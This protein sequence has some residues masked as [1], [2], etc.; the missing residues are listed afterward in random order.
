MPTPVATV[1]ARSTLPTIDEW[2]DIEPAPLGTYVVAKADAGLAGEIPVYDVPFGAPR[3]LVDDN[4]IDGV[5]SV[6]VRLVN[7]VDDDGVLVMR[8]VAGV[9][10]DDWILVQAPTRPHNQH[11]WVRGGDFAFGFTTKRIEID[12][13]GEGELL[14]FDEDDVLLRSPIVQG[15][16]SRP[17]P[18]HVTYVQRGVPAKDV[19][20]AYGE[21][22]LAMASFSEVLGTFGGG[23][24]PSNFIHGTNAPELMGHRVSS[25]EIRVPSEQ[26][27]AL[28]EL[29]T[30]G[31]P[32]LM[33][34]SS[35]SGRMTRSQ[36]LNQPM[37][38]APTI[39]FLDGAAGGQDAMTG[40]GPE[41]W[42][43]CETGE[44]LVC[45]NES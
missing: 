27:L 44:Q 43:R 3:S 42:R 22:I 30:P 36:I 21:A 18:T 20:P 26:L 12:L 33:Y 9:P 6:P 2:L 40:I 35:A 28:I 11:V 17:T 10:G 31:T 8:V 39:N 13:A 38:P 37:S 23:G 14:V 15:R 24:L 29:V 16:D 5:R 25:G 4:W 1:A 7:P 32:V 34:D 45:R 19:S 41:L